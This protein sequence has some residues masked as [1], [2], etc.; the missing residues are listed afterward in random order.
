MH[1]CVRMYSG[2]YAYTT[3]SPFANRLYGA[4]RSAHRETFARSC[5]AGGNAR[6]DF[7]PVPPYRIRDTFTSRI[8]KASA[9]V[10]QCRGRRGE[11]I[12]GKIYRMIRAAR[13]T[14]PDRFFFRVWRSQNSAAMIISFGSQIASLTARVPIHLPP[15]FK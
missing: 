6:A 13:Y 11:T 14:R 12:R 2:L 8:P 4:T 5:M 15:L 9:C 3:H 10:K 7:S 1:P